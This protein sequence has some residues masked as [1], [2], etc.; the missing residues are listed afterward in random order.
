MLRQQ[1]GKM[2]EAHARSFEAGRLESRS[3]QK[4][5][6]RSGSET[7]YNQQNQPATPS[8]L[9]QGA[10]SYWSVPEQN[11]FIRYI[12][13]FGRDFAAIAAHMGTK[14]QTMIRNH[15]QRQLDG[16]DPGELE[17]TAL[18]AEARRARGE[19]I[20]PPPRPTPIVRRKYD[21]DVEQ[22]QHAALPSY[23]QDTGASFN[24]ESNLPADPKGPG[25][26]KEQ[27][28]AAMPVKCKSISD[29]ATNTTSQ[30]Q[31]AAMLRKA[32]QGPGY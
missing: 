5:G 6:R 4:A 3:L 8:D 7:D 12:E 16:G 22:R 30:A 10:S 26:G 1:L 28:T 13:Y 21:R 23:A 17:R 19:D 18:A 20:G 11:D 32:L 14:T 2:H 25:F 9:K 15:Y 29:D 24:T 27:E 31:Q